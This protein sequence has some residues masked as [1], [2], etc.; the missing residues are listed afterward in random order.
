LSL[1]DAAKEVIQNKLT[2]LGDTDGIVAIDTERN[3]IMAFNTPGMYC[4]T[5]NDQGELYV[6]MYNT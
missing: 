2:N 5:M 3:M 4:A 6:G 1:K